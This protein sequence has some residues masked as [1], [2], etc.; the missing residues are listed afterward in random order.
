MPYNPQ[1]T[2]ADVRRDDAAT[3]IVE[4]H[5]PG[6]LNHPALGLSPFTVLADLAGF[7]KASGDPALEVP[8]MWRELAALTSGPP[9]AAPAPGPVDAAYEGSDVARASA[10]LTVIPGAEQWGVAEL[11]L[12]GPSHGNPFVDVELDA[13][14][15][16]GGREVRVGGFYDGEGTY[17]VRFLPPTAGTWTFETRSNARSLD[18]LAGSVDVA[19]PSQGNRG[20][21]VVRDTYHFA[22]EDGT[23]YLPLGTTAYAWTHQTSELE[24]LTLRTLDE[25]SFTKLRM[26]V[27]PKS[28][29]YNANEPARYPF[30]R[31]SD[32][33]WD[34]TRFNPAFFRHLEER[35][36]QLQEIGV[37]ADVIL[38]HPYDRWGFSQ[39]PAWADRLYTRY[40]VRRLAA[41]RN[42][43]WALANEWDFTKSK[44]VEDWEGIAAVIARED[45]A[46][47][48]TSIHNGFVFYDHTRPWVTHLSVQK[49]D[50][51]RTA[52]N[53][54]AWRR[55]GKP[56]V[57]DEIGYEGD[58][59]WGWGNLSPQELVRR[60][61]EG[62]IR[63]AYVNHGETY[64][65]DDQV[66]PW[67]QGGALHGTSPE[68]IAFL[69]QI[70]AE[71]PSGRFEPLANDFDALWG[72]ED[73]YRVV[74]FGLSRPRVRTL[75]LPSG[76]WDVDV[77]DTWA[78]TTETALTAATGTV[79]VT[80][81]VREYVAIRLR[82][83]V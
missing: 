26:C 11:E 62:A 48:L 2:I 82:R 19:A 27:F 33:S 79:T 32:G 17:R 60:C 1:A 34:H 31:T 40:V 47:H 59:E 14:F 49:N 16:Q 56:V 5:L 78:M 41:F 20:K 25:S 76:S 36:L 73:D 4:R 13:T 65:R 43:W 3:A 58:L 67:S 55:Y 63:G 30:E 21:V 74:Y 8:E 54:D 38:F 81:P 80:L 39:M 77:I 68:R 7:A 35:I 23:P 46:G 50:T 75:T 72:G 9:A 44:T 71:A 15:T 18:R 6:V 83:R 69:S 70:I 57:V 10:R 51:N 66:I 45:H 28:F 29:V 52:E 12:E 22:Y 37:E 24:E 61:W 53:V 64:H 42:I